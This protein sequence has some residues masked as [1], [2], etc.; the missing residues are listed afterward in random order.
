MTSP[1][2]KFLS[3]DVGGTKI[4]VCKFDGNYRLLSSNKIATSDFPAGSPE[5][6]RSIKKMI[7]DNLTP[8]IDRLG[9]SFNCIVK[10]GVI[11]HSS[12]LGGPTEYPLVQEFSK[13]F[14]LGV[15][16]EN[17]VN[18]MAL[19]ESR[20]G[21]GRDCQSFLLIN[22][23]TGL[24]LSYVVG[25]KLIPGFTNN[26]GEISQ[27]EEIVPELNYKSF[28]IDDFLSG[29]GV[30]NIY[31]ELAQKELTAQQ[32]FSVS[33]EDPIARKTIDIFI[34]HLARFLAEVSYFYNPQRI[35]LNGSLKE[36]AD[37]F[38]P[39]ALEIYRRETIGFFQFQ[40]AVTSSIDHA[41]C[42]G[43]LLS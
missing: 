32:I 25:G 36:S 43:A 21:Q 10:D 35:I 3:L 16:L 30:S 2:A 1:P 18:A 26:A 6:L 22:L 14:G 19:A 12:L 7:A 15:S 31:R 37:L 27:K 11:T 9:V 38:L 23:G 4:E 40:D 24:R 39:Q 17:D 41:A 13:E 8:G 34:S 5:F 42:L 28:K 20:F 33:K 29:K